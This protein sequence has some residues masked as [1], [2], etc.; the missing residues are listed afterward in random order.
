MILLYFWL[1]SADLRATGQGCARLVF[2]TLQGANQLKNSCQLFFRPADVTRSQ[3]RRQHRLLLVI[4]YGETTQKS[5]RTAGE[6]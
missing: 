5:T 4:R 6:N 1:S 3:V 2:M